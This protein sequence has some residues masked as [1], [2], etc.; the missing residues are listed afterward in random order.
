MFL[1]YT[2]RFYQSVVRLRKNK[3]GSFFIDNSPLAHCNQIPFSNI[4]SLHVP[5]LT[6]HSI[7]YDKHFVCFVYEYFP[8]GLQLLAGFWVNRISRKFRF[9]Y[10]LKGI[11]LPTRGIYRRRMIDKIDNVI[12]QMSCE[13]HFFKYGKRNKK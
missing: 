7:A 12:R 5:H 8:P 3:A 11:S 4:S 1:Y 2:I 6:K 13:N 10:C 9:Y